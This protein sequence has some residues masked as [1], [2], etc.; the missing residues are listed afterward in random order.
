MKLKKLN[1]LIGPILAT[2]LVGSASAVNYSWSGAGDATTWSQGANWVGGVVPPADSTTFQ[3]ALGTGNPTTSPLPI[4]IGASTAAYVADNVFGPEWGQTL[5]ISG[6]LASGLFF[7]PVGAVGGP[8]STINLLGTGSLSSV[9]SLF[10]GDPFWI[11]AFT[12][13]NVTVNLYDSSQ[14]STKYLA[15][16]GHLNIYGGTVTVNNALLT[17]TPTWG[18]WG[19]GSTTGPATTDATRLI[20]LAGGQLVVVGDATS[21]MNDLISRG[22]L[23][24]SG[25]VGNVNIDTTS[26]PGWTVVTVPEPAGLTLFGLG[27]L[28]LLLRRRLS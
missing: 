12:I 16:A 2:C 22:V 8:T 26:M 23:R 9:D 14:M 21:Q 28:A 20:N 19:D 17:G 15:L 3:I 6:S 10:V 7:T 13:P 18:P 27:G 4:T 5:N 11:N 1:Y 24:G 25:I